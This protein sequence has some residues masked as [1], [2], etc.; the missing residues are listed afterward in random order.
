[1]RGSITLFRIFGID[2]KLHLSWWL[3]FVLIS[4]SLAT[5]FFPHYFPG[6]QN[7]IYWLMGIVSV[8]LLFVSV[9]LHEL[10]HSL[11]A[12]SRKI[13][14]ESITLFF[15]GGVAGIN[16]EDLKPSSEFLMAVAGPLF[17]L[18]LFAIFYGLYLI[19]GSSFW[20]PITYYLYQLNLILALFNLIP[21]YPLDGGRAF[22]ALLFMHYKDIK[23]ATKI[24]VLGG[25]IFAL[26]LALFGILTVV[27]RQASGLWFLFLGGFLYYIAGLSYEQVLV[28]DAL[29]SIPVRTLL[30]K[31]FVKLD[32]SMRFSDFLQ[33]YLDADE[34]VF[35]VQNKSFS[36][37]MDIKGLNPIPQRMQRL[38]NLKQVSIPLSTITPLQINETA[39]NAYQKFSAQNV[40]ILPVMQ[41]GVLLGFVARRRVMHRLIWSLKYSIGVGKQNKK[42]LVEL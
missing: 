22:R 10:S 25:R 36:G 18:L 8:L 15:F 4:W 11:V 21:G 41:K 16:D 20:T 7:T 29:G 40:D 39:F 19:N 5:S 28:K 26:L 37:M 30:T 17:S 2:I 27:N 9:L 6:Q 1:M 33:K 14:V 32:P 31:K 3:V 24:A 34:E 38:L 23:K 13:K 35:L 42:L 12:R